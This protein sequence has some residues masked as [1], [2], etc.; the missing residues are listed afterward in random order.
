MRMIFGLLGLLMVVAIMGFLAKTQL[1]SVTSLPAVSAI[2]GQATSQ[3]E[4]L[5]D[6]AAMN[7]AANMAEQSKL[8]QQ[9]VKDQI[10]QAMEAAA[11]ARAQAL[12]K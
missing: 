1:K 7:P 8:M 4:K 6:A 11:A 9:Q 2:S 5:P 12:E 10:G 3:P